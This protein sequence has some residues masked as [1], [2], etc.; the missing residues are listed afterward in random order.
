MHS[1]Y[2]LDNYHHHCHHNHYRHHHERP[3]G[4][5]A[6]ALGAPSEPSGAGFDAQMLHGIMDQV[7]I[8]NDH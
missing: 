1:F 7:F 5:L 6:V 8:I 4:L 3:E 2:N